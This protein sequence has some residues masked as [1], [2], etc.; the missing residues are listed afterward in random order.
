MPSLV[1]IALW[2]AGIYLAICL[3]T[4]L[5]Q[6]RL[7]YF[8]DTEVVPVPTG[9]RW[10]G[11]EPVT[12]RTQDGVRIEA[13]FWPGT[14]DTAV[15]L[16][17]GNAGHRG[18]RLGWMAD[19]RARGWPVFLLDYR[20]YGGSDGSPSE[21][22]LVLD[23]EAAVDWLATRGHERVVYL[24]SSLGCGVATRL[25]VRRPAAGL[26]LQSGAASLA[27]VGQQAYPF[28]PVG[29]LM[30][31]RFDVAADAARVRCPSLS[32]HGDR[33]RDIRLEHGRA[34]HAALGGE[35]T[36]WVVEG[37]G[38]NDVVDRAGHAWF[39]RVHAFLEG[40]PR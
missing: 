11:L 29:L 4:F 31:D 38:H 19:L 17:H 35:K 1:R 36:W 37:A 15:L 6:R 32:I 12:L 9:A 8:P 23:A 18:H 2:I 34:L 16:L 3:A 24:G 13:F 20:G 26:V 5:F 27:A 7:Q 14:R 30:K 40:L 39:D 28:L 33:D 21:E 25:A 10:R 22:G